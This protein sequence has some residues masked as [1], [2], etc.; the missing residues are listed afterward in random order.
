[1]SWIDLRE[2]TYDVVTMKPIPPGRR[3]AIDVAAEQELAAWRCAVGLPAPST[4][5]VCV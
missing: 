5:T 1:M 2:F 3:G 4:R